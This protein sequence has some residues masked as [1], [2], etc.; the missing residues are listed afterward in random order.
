MSSLSNFVAQG[1]I[2]PTGAVKKLTIDGLEKEQFR[3]YRIPLEY[4]YYNDQNGR[5]N[6]A[7]KRYRIKH[8][9]RELNPAV[10]SVDEFYNNKFEEFIENSN[11]GAMK[12][13]KN[14]IKKKSQQEP[15]VV[16]DDGRVIDGNRRYTALRMIQ[17]ETG[18]PGYIDAVILN[19]NIGIEVDAKRIKK[20]ELDLQMGREERVDYDPI[21]RVFEVYDDVVVRGLLTPQEYAESIGKGNASSV[22]KDISEAKLI[23]SYLDFIHARKDAFYLAKDLKLDGPMHEILTFMRKY[24]GDDKDAVRD[25]L[26]AALANSYAN[27]GGDV[28]RELRS[29]IR[30]VLTTSVRHDFLDK[31]EDN[32][33]DIFTALETQAKKNKSKAIESAEEVTEALTANSQVVKSSDEFKR[34]SNLMVRRGGRDADRVASLNTIKDCVDSLKEIRDCL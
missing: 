32:V 33:D 5:I 18:K 31:S 9:N 21:G 26:F 27:G 15:G 25:T 11:P 7:Y 34:F 12:A 2:A 28:S 17:K 13:T 30:N 19:L 24:K 14:S 3:V 29:L 22:N 23:I 10:D 4:L 6:T 16:L 8:P 1:K 20:L